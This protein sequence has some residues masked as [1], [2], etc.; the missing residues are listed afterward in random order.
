MAC[1]INLL[2]FGLLLVLLIFNFWKTKKILFSN[3]LFNVLFLT[4]FLLF[5]FFSSQAIY[6][7]I[8]YDS[9]QKPELIYQGEMGPLA[10]GGECPFAEKEGILCIF[11]DNA[12]LRE[13]NLPQ[14]QNK[15]IS[16]IYQRLPSILQWRI[17]TNAYQRLSSEDKKL[18][19]KFLRE[20]DGYQLQLLF[21]NKI[22][23]YK[24]IIDQELE[25]LRK[26]T[27]ETIYGKE[28]NQ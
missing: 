13:L 11:M 15:A 17:M 28:N 18:F 26:E 9:C 10:F 8:K 12:V 6:N 23:D 5:A 22:P 7:L 20:G 3:F 4:L 21:Y 19:E 24:S 1:L 16:R 14:S 2:I 27:I 25:K